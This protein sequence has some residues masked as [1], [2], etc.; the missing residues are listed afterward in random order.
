LNP[1][2]AHVKVAGMNRQPSWDHFRS[3]QRCH[4]GDEKPDNR[5]SRFDRWLHLVLFGKTCAIILS[6]LTPSNR[7]SVIAASRSLG[8]IFL[9]VRLARHLLVRAAFA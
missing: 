6:I 1:V 9:A 4:V 7:I 5:S 3:A 2:N 8:K